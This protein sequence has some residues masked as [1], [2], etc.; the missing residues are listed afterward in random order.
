MAKY[1]LVHD[2]G[3]TGNKACVFNKKGNIVGS[4][5]YT[6]KSYF[7]KIG[8][9]EQ[10]PE[11]WWKAICLSTKDLLDVLNISKKDILCM[12]FSGHMMGCVP[13]D[14]EGNLLLKK[15]P[16]YADSRASKQARYIAKKIGG[17]DKWYR[18]TGTGQVP[19]CYSISKY[20]WIR[21][22]MPSI[23]NRVWKFLNTKDYIVYRFTGITATDYSD[24]SDMGLL[25]I[26]KGIW[27]KEIIN[28]AG[29]SEDL[30][31][32]LHKS[33]DVI[34]KITK[35]A[36]DEIQLPSG[37]PIVMGGGDV[38]CAATGAGI[39]RQ[40]LYYI[41]IGS[42]NWIGTFINKPL[43][44]NNI[45][46]SVFFHIIPDRYVAHQF[47][48]GGGICYQWLR[49]N[50]FTL[51]KEL[52]KEIE[53]DPWEYMNFQAEKIKLGSDNLIFLPYLRGDWSGHY[54]PNAR[55]AFIG[56][57]LKHGKFHIIRSVLE[58]VG[59]SLRILLDMFKEQ[60]LKPDNIRI[61]GG[62]ARSKIWKQIIADICNIPVS[63]PLLTQ[64][65]TSLGAAIAALVGIDI[66]NNFEEAIKIIQIEDIITPRDDNV[67]LY[68][69]L[70]L[71]FKKAYKA[72]IPLFNNLSKLK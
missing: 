5:Y 17:F 26:N 56:L 14:R 6:Y 35:K 24:A 3:T 72:L 61:I 57:N 21:E 64:E 40:G 18:L 23:F 27:S 59:F 51:E 42:A 66:F 69:E 2:V 44:D 41:S 58:G 67:K 48:I 43:L 63:T 50:L 49:D 62:G 65:A 15:V 38:S 11:E 33:T 7:P 54:N 10:A 19:D 20:L 60:G 47:M 28:A 8:Y 12:T 9:Q 1:V 34:G 36:A 68:N 46:P 13:I 52:I 22:N 37:I 30:L 31:P 45:R 55:G 39:N 16:I 25:D 4:S 71:I 29:I 32:N 53:I 70:Y